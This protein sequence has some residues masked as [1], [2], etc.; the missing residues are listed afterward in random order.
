MNRALYRVQDISHNLLIR[1]MKQLKGT[2]SNYAIKT[3][4][5]ITHKHFTFSDIMT[6]GMLFLI[7]LYQ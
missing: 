4:T 3:I 7:L 1:Q 2:F 5:Q 6:N